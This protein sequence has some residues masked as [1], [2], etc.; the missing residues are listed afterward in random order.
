[1]YTI[2]KTNNRDYNRISECLSLCLSLSVSLSL[3]IYIYIYIYIY[4]ANKQI[5]L[6]QITTKN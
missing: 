1:M 6:Q 3:Y 4:N 2:S 5:Y